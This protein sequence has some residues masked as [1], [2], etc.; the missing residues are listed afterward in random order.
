MK[1]GSSVVQLRWPHFRGFV[2]TGGYGIGSAGRTFPSRR[3]VLLG[4][5]A[6]EGVTEAPQGSSGP[7]AVLGAWTRPASPGLGS[8][9]G[10]PEGP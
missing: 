7:V 2:A 10:L 6:L 8:L 4:G 3:R 1:Y 5:T 9:Y